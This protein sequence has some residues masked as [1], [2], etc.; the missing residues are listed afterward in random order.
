MSAAPVT[1]DMS[2]AQPIQAD[3]P[4]ALDM[5]KA[6]P[7]GQTRGDDAGVIS[8]AAKSFA[9]GIGIPT[10]KEELEAAQPSLAE[11]IGGPAVTA[12][13]VIYNYGK[14]LYNQGRESL[15]EVGDAIQNVR[16]GQPVLENIGKAGAAG[17]DLALKGVLA[18]VGGT[19]T[20]RAGEDI[21]AGKIPEAAGDIGAGAVNAVAGKDVASG[22]LVS[23]Q[24]PKTETIAGTE[25]PLT[26]GQARAASVPGGGTTVR[27]LEDLTRNLPGGGPLRSVAADQ[28]GAAREIL[29]N[30]A[31]TTGAETSS[32]PTSI[33]ENAQ[34][35]AEAARTKGGALYQEIGRSADKADLT[36]TVDAAHSILTDDSLAKTLPRSAREALGKV[37]SSLSEKESIARQI[38][39]KGLSDLDEAQQSEVSKAMDGSQDSDGGF[40]A[41]LKARSEL[42]DS[43]SGMKDAADRFQMHKALDQ[44][45]QAVNDSLSA[46]D[47]A[48]GSNLTGQLSEAKKLWSQKYAFEEL[49]DGLQSV[50]RDEPHSGA[51]QI[52][53]AKFQSLINDLDPRGEKGTTPLQRMFPDDPQSVKDL[54]ELADFMGR[55]QSHAG[56][57]AGMMVRMRILGAKESALGLL[58]NAAGFSYLMSNRG[59]PRLLLEALTNGKDT[60]KLSALAGALNH[61]AT[62]VNGEPPNLDQ[63]RAASTKGESNI[64]PSVTTNRNS[65]LSDSAS[66][67]T[68]ATATT[69]NSATP[70]ANSNP[71]SIPTPEGRVPVTVPGGKS[72]HFPDQKSADQFKQAAGIQ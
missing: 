62:G 56:G 27:P 12:G 11:K 10:S 16:E 8:R 22:H 48:S 50:M 58:T 60:V 41:V 38:Y 28:Q 47:K 17:M 20:A 15:G 6:V 31:A 25:V 46:H 69:Q 14:N 24:L 34:R 21:A 37:A 59:I 45:D 67:T 49:R 52:N 7:I 42:A 13:K 18:P 39:G 63:S 9:Q 36:P 71:N 29:A 23:E 64:V 4:V 5:S 66:S 40:A 55:N 33:E 1:L 72:Y 2:K 70:A 57:M 3:T 68:P 54:H 30:K 43:A 19:A 32:A 35:A 51:R 65:T 44:F 61:L 53:G 26:V